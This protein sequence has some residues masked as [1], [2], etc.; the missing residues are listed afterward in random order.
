MDHF[1][2][3]ETAPLQQHRLIQSIVHQSAA[4]EP[5]AELVAPVF[6]STEIYCSGLLVGTSNLGDLSYRRAEN[7]RVPRYKGEFQVKGGRFYDSA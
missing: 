1:D 6:E 4:D 2:K 7:L 3:P 5:N